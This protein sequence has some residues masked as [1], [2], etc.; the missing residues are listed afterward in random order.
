MAR[1]A[2]HLLGRRL[3]GGILIGQA[4]VHPVP[5]LDLVAG[6][7]PMPT[8]ESVEAGRG[9]LEVARKVQAGERLLVLLSGGASALMVVPADGVTLEDKRDVTATLLAAGVDIEALN[10]VRK[11]LSAIKGGWLAAATPVRC[12]TLV[13]SDVV[14]DNVSVIG[15]GPT[16]ADA[17]TFENGLD[18]MRHAGGLDAFPPRAVTRLERGAA[19]EH[20]ET[21]KPGDVRLVN[22]EVVLAGG[23]RD[24]MNGAAEEASRRGYRTHVLEGAVTGE[25]R[26][27]ARAYLAQATAVAASSPRPL[28]IVSSGETTVRV[29]GSGR[30]GRNQEFVL[31]AAPGLGAFGDLAM[32]A[33]V[34]TDGVDGPTPAAGALAD[35]FTL[36]R[37]RQAGLAPPG[38]FLLRNDAYRF[39]EA[40]G[41]LIQTGPTGTNVGDLQILLT[42]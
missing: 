31:A 36:T 6:G 23:R 29:A 2:V 41:D 1:A 27:A 40:L 15:S 42:R 4:P 13:I 25:A 5:R 9:A 32:C 19:G 38:D 21:P 35:T 12:H 16:V 30:G 22:G 26:D 28:C 7:H 33:S 20:A 37:A 24:A 3:K 18:V 11:H 8:L 39:F 14:G 34:G 17:S 10:M